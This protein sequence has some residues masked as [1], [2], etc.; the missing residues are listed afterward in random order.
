MCCQSGQKQRYKAVLTLHT[1]T[2]YITIF[3]VF[4][5]V[6][7]NV[8]F[9]IISQKIKLHTPCGIRHFDRPKQPGP[10]AHIQTQQLNKYSFRHAKRNL[11]CKMYTIKIF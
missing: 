3:L 4:I 2:T 1:H 8:P 7:K 5:D 10:T 9:P 11:T 6:D